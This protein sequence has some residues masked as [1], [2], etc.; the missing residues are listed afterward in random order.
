M[1]VLGGAVAH[2]VH[3]VLTVGGLHDA[4]V[5]SLAAVLIAPVLEGG[6]HGALGHVLIET[7][8]GVAAGILGVLLGKSRETVLGAVPAVQDL[9]GPGQDHLV[10]GLLTLSQIQVGVGDKDVTDIVVQSLVPLAAV[11][12]RHIDVV[13]SVAGEDLGVAGGPGLVKEPVAG[14]TGGVGQI[15]SAGIGPAVLLSQ[16]LQV[17]ALLIG[18]QQSLSVGHGLVHGGL[19]LLLGGL[20]SVALLVGGAGGRA[21]EG[22]VAAVHDVV[23][24]L[25]LLVVRLDFLVG[26]GDAVMVR[27]EVLVRQQ[28]V[29]HQPLIDLRGHDG[30]VDGVEV[31]AVGV[32]VGGGSLLHLL[33]VVLQLRLILLVQG[34]S[35][36]SGGVQRR[37][38][39]AQGIHRFLLEVLVPGL[40]RTAPGILVLQAGAG[41]QANQGGVAPVGIQNILIGVAVIV[42]HVR[43]RVVLPVNGDGGAA[44]LDDP[45]VIHHQEDSHYHKYNGQSRVQDIGLPLSGLLLRR[46]GGLGVH[47]A[48]GKKLLPLFLLSGCAHLVHSFQKFPPF[49]QEQ[50]KL[51]FPPR[52]Q[53]DPAA[54]HTTLYLIVPHFASTSCFRIVNSWAALPFPQKQEQ[55]PWMFQRSKSERRRVSGAAH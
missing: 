11:E 25:V 43:R 20:H 46:T 39:Q 34:H 48:A 15:C 5:A 24:V 37:V 1:P 30:A 36:L 50:P 21:V 26:E 14:S 54:Q 13:G 3:D 44:A 47:A 9:L 52:A 12:H 7:A 8:V 22:D 53:S 18:G 27:G 16:G 19:I 40:F 38:D 51:I 4:G 31:G 23:A 33:D 2:E 49:T 45:G 10:G 32:P 17:S 41:V 28:V 35:L 42:A 55:G 6:H 29:L